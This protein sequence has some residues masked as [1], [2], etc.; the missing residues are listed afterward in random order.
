MYY[1]FLQGFKCCAM[2]SCRKPACTVWHPYYANAC[3][4]QRKTCV[5]IHNS[6]NIYFLWLQFILI[7]YYIFFIELFALYWDN[8]L[9]IL[10]I[11]GFWPM[12]S[13]CYRHGVVSSRYVIS[14]VW[15]DGYGLCR[16]TLKSLCFFFTTFLSW[17]AKVVILFSCVKVHV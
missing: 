8:Y 16:W 5:L 12:P 10:K 17:S 1:S 7:A 11:R 9:L 6:M 14:T 4:S 13:A 3:W 2:W 15:H